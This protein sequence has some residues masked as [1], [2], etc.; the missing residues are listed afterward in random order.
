MRSPG[1]REGP[2]RSLAAEESR[3][4][5]SGGWLLDILVLTWQ[6]MGLGLAHLAVL[7]FFRG[8]GVGKLGGL[9]RE[10]HDISKCWVF[11]S[12]AAD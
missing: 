6:V 2:H 12:S 8:G 1:G 11:F 4:V 9:R 3:E 7:S 5:G 10:V